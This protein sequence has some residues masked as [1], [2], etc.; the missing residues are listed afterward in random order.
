MFIATFRAE[1]QAPLGAACSPTTPSR[2]PSTPLLRELENHLLRQSAFHSSQTHA[3][4]AAAPCSKPTMSS[5]RASRQCP[6]RGHTPSGPPAPGY[7]PGGLPWTQGKLFPNLP[8]THR[9]RVLSPRTVPK[10]EAIRHSHYRRVRRIPKILARSRH[11][12]TGAR[13]KDQDR[14]LPRCRRPAISGFPSSSSTPYQ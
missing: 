4:P 7:V 5:G 1:S 8:L 11:G 14:R 10:G 13:I 6:P 3:P 9:D 12:R 2:E